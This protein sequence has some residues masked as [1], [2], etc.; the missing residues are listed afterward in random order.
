MQSVAFLNLQLFYKLCSCLTLKNFPKLL[1]SLNWSSHR[2]NMRWYFQ[3]CSGSWRWS[4]VQ[5]LGLLMGGFRSARD[6]LG[7]S[8]SLG[9]VLLLLVFE[10][11][12][13]LLWQ[14]YFSRLNNRGYQQIPSSAIL[15]IA[16]GVKSVEIEIMLILLCSRWKATKTSEVSWCSP[17]APGFFFLGC[18]GTFSCNCWSSWYL[19][20]LRKQPCTHVFSVWASVS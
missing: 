7:C 2:A 15:H 18:G 4:F 14:Q 8:Q 16:I 3:I 6:P 19:S 5:S 10:I 13:M 17:E 20:L 9:F 1:T 12:A 11:P